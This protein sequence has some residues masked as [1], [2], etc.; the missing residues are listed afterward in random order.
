MRVAH[1]VAPTT[2]ITFDDRETDLI[3]AFRART[4][5]RPEVRMTVERLARAAVRSKLAFGFTVKWT[6]P[7]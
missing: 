3:D 2:H 1:R 4:V 6:P 5:G 7:H